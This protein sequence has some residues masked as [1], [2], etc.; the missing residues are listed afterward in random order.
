MAFYGRRVTSGDTDFGIVGQ[1]QQRTS[2][3]N[4]MPENGW[5]HTLG[6]WGG[7]N[8]G[9]GTPTVKIGVWTTS[10]LTPATR[11]A[12]HN[13]ITV[14]TYQSYGG[15]GQS[16]SVPVQNVNTAL[17]PGSNA[18]KLQANA[19]YAIGI[20]PTGATVGHAMV[21]AS[22]INGDNEQFYHRDGVTTP[23]N[24]NGYTYSSNEGWISAW[25][26]YQPNRAPSAS[27]SSP[28]GLITTTSPSFQGSFS[29]PD[30]I[31]GDHL[32]NLHIQVVRV[33]NNQVMWD[34]GSLAATSTE[35][36]SGTFN[37]A[38]GG[39]TLVA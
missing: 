24:P 26:E 12:Y 38:Y 19:N 5:G 10:N 16:Y 28:N 13:G 14:S 4:R 35:R 8:L 25:I 31:Y 21:Q 7:R 30:S 20:L 9:G 1:N 37:R 32:N 6:F 22:K 34:S 36:N 3:Y 27:T 39:S 17:S 11:M 15:D 18:I 33:S 23:T 2:V 29:D